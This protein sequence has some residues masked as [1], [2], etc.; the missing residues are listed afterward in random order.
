MRRIGECGSR[1]WLRDGGEGGILCSNTRIKFGLVKDGRVVI[2]ATM[3]SQSEHG[4]AE[5]LPALAEELRNL[6]K[7]NAPGDCAGL[8]VSVPSLVDVAS[9]R[10]LAEYDYARTI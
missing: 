1:I 7:K 3:P 4:L 6:E 8:S 10:A 5:R 9:G 2:Q